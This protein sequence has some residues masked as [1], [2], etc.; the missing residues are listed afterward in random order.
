MDVAAKKMNGGVLC[1]QIKHFAPILKIDVIHPDDARFEGRMVHE[2]KGNAAVCAFQS[3]LEPS[4][5]CRTKAPCVMA[6][7][8][9][10]GV[11]CDQAVIG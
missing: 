1:K 6:K 11:E 9:V 3:G 7:G 5:P 10:F 4:H 2:N 8:A